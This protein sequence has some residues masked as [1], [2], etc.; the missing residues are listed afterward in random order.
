MAENGKKSTH[1][2]KRFDFGVVRRKLT[3]NSSKSA[4]AVVKSAEAAVRPAAAKPT[5]RPIAKS[6]AKPVTKESAAVKPTIVNK[7]AS[8]QKPTISTQKTA[9]SAQRPAKASPET[10]RKPLMVNRGRFIDF[11]PAH[12]TKGPSRVTED[13]PASTENL[14]TNKPASIKA[15]DPDTTP[16]VTSRGLR[17]DFVRKSAPTAAS[18]GVHTTPGTH[19]TPGVHTTPVRPASTVKITSSSTSITSPS[20]TITSSST[21]ISP[22]STVADVLGDAPDEPLMSDADLAAALAGFADA[23]PVEESYNPAALGDDN[24]DSTSDDDSTTDFASELDAFDELSDDIL[25]GQSIGDDIDRIEAEIE[26]EA[27]DFVKE[28]KPL[29]EDPLVKIS[30]A[31]EEREHEKEAAEAARFKAEVKEQAREAAKRSP[32][33]ALYST[34]NGRSPFLTSVNVEKRPL[35]ASASASELSNLAKSKKA[36]PTSSSSLLASSRSKDERFS[37]LALL[38]NSYRNRMKKQLEDD[39]KV[40]HRETMIISAP[41]VK[42]HNIALIIGILLTILLGAGVGLVVYL[43]F[44]Q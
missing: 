19:T 7:A 11:A 34:T 33:A 13:L 15:S 44:F 17:I 25:A 3:K 2:T 8:A 39:A 27:N 40:I 32:Y 38:K 10:L 26:A 31:R 18:S 43:V 28:P 36:K 22:S 12:P 42:G 20:T 23:T 1:A 37:T 14:S 24:Y 4:E 30:K 9:T 35:S 29:F 6:A 41:E 16:H 21:R 5:A